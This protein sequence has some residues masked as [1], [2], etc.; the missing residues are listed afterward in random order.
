[1]KKP[2]STKEK[3]SDKIEESDSTENTL[4]QTS[5]SSGKKETSETTIKKAPA[6]KSVSGTTKKAEKKAAEQKAA[7]VKTV[8]GKDKKTTETK[9]TAAKPKTA[10]KQ[11]EVK[12]VLQLRFHTQ[13]GQSIWI[14]SNG[15]LLGDSVLKQMNYED[16]DHWRLDLI[17]RPELLTEDLHYKYHVR[18]ADG[19]FMDD[20]QEK[21]IPLKILKFP[22]L[23]IRDFW[24]YAGY[25]DNVYDKVPF[26]Y[27]IKRD[28]V[29]SKAV[30]ATSTHLFQVKVPYLRPN[31]SVCVLGE[32]EA[33]GAWDFS[34]Y[35]PLNYNSQ[36]RVWETALP[37]KV[38]N[39]HVAYKYGIFDKQTKEIVR[40]ENGANRI[41]FTLQEKGLVVQNDGF[42]NLLE[43]H[44][45][46]AGVN[47][48]LF[49]I[50]SNK[51]LGIG[52]LGSIYSMVDWMSSVGL[53]LLQLLPINDT[54]V[55]KTWEDS[56]PYSAISVYALHPIY[57]DIN[58]LLTA[59]LKSQPAIKA[60][61]ETGKQLNELAQVDYEAVLH[62]KWQLIE[63][64]Y[65]VLGKQTID[66]DGYQT[67][68]RENSSWLKAYAAFSVLRDQ[69]QSAV[70]DGWKD[71]HAY[72]DPL[73]DKLYKSKKDKIQLYFFVQYILSRQ[74]SD[75]VQ[76]AHTHQVALKG[77]IPI[78]VDRYSVDVWQHPHLFNTHMQAG[79]PPDFFT[80]DGQNWGFPT[81]RWDVME[82]DDFAWW[83]KRL[84]NMAQYFDA[85]R[86]DHI[87][88]FF[89]IWSVPESQVQGVLGYF[90]PCMPIDIS[91]LEQWQIPFDYDRYCRP[92]IN[93]Q[94]LLDLF[95]DKADYVK[96][97]FLD[98]H[99]N[100]NY[101]F[102]PAFDTQ[103][104][105]QQAFKRNE[106]DESDIRLQQ[107][108]F[109]LMA[110]VLL[111]PDHQAG[112]FHCRFA[113][114][115]TSSYA[116]LS[117]WE[118]QQLYYLYLNYFFERQDASWRK[119]G[120]RQLSAVGSVTDMMMCGEDLG[121]VPKVVPEVMGQL[122]YL[123]LKVQ[124]MGSSEHAVFT[125]PLE[126][127]FLNIVT[128]ATHDMPPIRN[129]WNQEPTEIK[130]AFYRSQLGIESF[131]PEICDE[132]IVSQIVFNHLESPALWSIF[133]IQDLL[134][135]ENATANPNMDEDI[136]NR[137]DVARFYWRY[138][139]HLSVEKLQ[140]EKQL[141][142]KIKNLLQLSN[143]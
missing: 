12:V 136:I 39:S 22:F 99:G 108:L 124:R 25:H 53:K 143:R 110:N 13:V 42:I 6:K 73:F 80:K 102:K 45:K 107:S 38:A 34:K 126:V 127:G 8:N 74:L 27:L 17:L 20:Y 54:T 117:D 97:I 10:K 130:D 87:L 48:P 138:R 91:E 70:Y 82:K 76:Y 83:K 44:W 26:D 123:G 94:V 72:S 79:A 121:M 19:S 63:A 62:L 98:H 57:V 89:R 7:P 114:Y 132:T 23:F 116:H 135:M 66:T 28:A 106:I 95:G 43:K 31:E 77:D 16:N 109:S 139:M 60:L 4:K 67:F 37:I 118:K 75:A 84:V 9:R 122:G 1:M 51:D 86:I 59:E 119:I 11:L 21:T 14:T 2:V 58:R 35:R 78:G 112:K 24:S 36:M 69:Y 32:D 92:F 50:R 52:D 49:S 56:Y 40:L 29:V 100:G 137:P 105:I 103:K 3:K 134:S 115:E 71:A 90:Q 125:N 41:S 68:V 5:R 104:K 101:R 120:Y 142:G 141:N 46:G 55:T 61:L 15:L 81:Y 88:G 18:N 140:K 93:V 30:A 47:I 129:W 113:L 133:L 131:A 33:L 65:V 111:I 85:I 96:T 128:P 64:A